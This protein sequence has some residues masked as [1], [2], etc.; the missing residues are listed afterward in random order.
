MCKVD[1]VIGSLDDDDIVEDVC[2][3]SDVDAFLVVVGDDA[4]VLQNISSE[5]LILV[6]MIVMLLGTHARKTK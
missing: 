2:V 1:V 6:M 3:T 4:D 5:L